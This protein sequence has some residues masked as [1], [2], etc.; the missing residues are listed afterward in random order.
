VTTTTLEMLR[1]ADLEILG[2]MPYSSNAT[3]LVE[4][5]HHDRRF[6]AVYKPV[7]GE[8]PL[9]DF[10]AGLHR[11]EHAAYLLDEVL[12]WGLV[13]PTVV[14]EGPAGE[15]SVQAFVEADHDQHYFTLLGDERHHRALRRLAVFDLLA[16]SADRKGGHVLV[17]GEHRLWAIDN[18]LCFHAELKLRTVVWDFAG[19]PMP[20]DLLTDVA[21]VLEAEEDEG[22]GRLHSSLD[23]FEREALRTRARAVVAEGRFPHDPTGRRWP[24][25][26]V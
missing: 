19:E 15:G 1:E 9:W 8:R 2:R 17:D 11:R 6:H 10:P 21:R 26:V 7:R 25:P 24:W 20:D 5:C 12:G 22:L 14:R 4:G 13:P 3:L 16:N 23:P 18:G